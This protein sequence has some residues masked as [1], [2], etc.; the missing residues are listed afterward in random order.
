MSVAIEHGG[1]AEARY[2]GGQHRTRSHREAMDYSVQT[3]RSLSWPGT[4]T[5]SGRH[6]RPRLFAFHKAFEIARAAGLAQLAQ[7]L[8]LDLANPFTR[9][10]ELLANLFK[11]VVGLLANPK[12]HAQNLFLTRCQ[13][14]QHLA[15]LLTQIALD[16][17]F[18]R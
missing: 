12:S 1:V 14:R 9:D 7:R 5:E 8:G 16:R 13:G 11:R 6:G 15:G 4:L 17:S 2:A 10:G 3:R 18:D